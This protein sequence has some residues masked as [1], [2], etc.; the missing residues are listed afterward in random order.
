MGCGHWSGGHKGFQA[1]RADAELERSVREEEMPLLFNDASTRGSGTARIFP[2]PQLCRAVPYATLSLPHTGVTDDVLDQ[3]FFDEEE[4]GA[5][6]GESCGGGGG[7]GGREHGGGLPL[8]ESHRRGEAPRLR[9]GGAGGRGGARGSGPAKGCR[10]VIHS[11]VAASLAATLGST[12]PSPS[13]ASLPAPPPLLS[14]PTPQER[15]LPTYQKWQIIRHAAEQVLAVYANRSNSQWIEDESWAAP[16]VVNTTAASASSEWRRRG[17][18]G[19]G[20]YF[21]DQLKKW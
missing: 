5:G 13:R 18:G 10:N 20:V 7:G 9:S 2:H 21:H 17:R 6:L 1:V 4:V 19:E 3:F 15:V 14:P 16:N 11:M 12:L 8:T